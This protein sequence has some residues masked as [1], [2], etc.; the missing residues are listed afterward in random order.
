MN[1]NTY[2][3]HDPIENPYDWDIYESAPNNNPP[4]YA[5]GAEND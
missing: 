3:N 5:Y 1:E 4:V 2:V